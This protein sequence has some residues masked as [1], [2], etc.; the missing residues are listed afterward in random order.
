MSAPVVRPADSSLFE[1]LVRQHEAQVY[2]LAYRML[3]HREEAEDITQ[4]ALLKAFESLSALREPQA[5]RA[6]VGRIAA[7]LCL[8]RLRSPSYRREC[9]SD[10]LAEYAA[11]GPTEEEATLN[12][13]VRDEV[14]RLPRHYQELLRACYVEGRSY[15]EMA[16]RAGLEVTTVKMRLFRAR[17][18]LRARLQEAMG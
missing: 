5:R 15:E 7:S 1:E 4:E 12:R 3:R 10:T 17:R 14:A 9:H 11:P 8:A 6:W 18:R 2:R 16:R 13:L